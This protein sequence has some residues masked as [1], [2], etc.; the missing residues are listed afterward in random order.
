MPKKIM[1][2]MMRTLGDVIVSTT[3]VK[4]LKK[5]YPD[6]EIYFL[7]NR[8]YGELLRNNPD[9]FQVMESEQ[10][11]DLN[12]IFFEASSGKYDVCF[13]PYQVRGECNIW[14]QR[15]ETR[16]QHLV[17][18]YWQ[19]MGMHRQ[20][21]DRECYLYPSAEDFAKAEEHVS[22]DVPRVALHSTTGVPTKDWPYF[23]ELADLLI[24]AGY[25]P[26]Q[27]G[28]RE[29]KKIERAVDLRG[30]MGFLELAAFLSKCAVFVG[31]DSGPSY[32]ADSMKT[33]CVVIQGSTSPVTSG[34][35]SARVI[36]LFADKTGYPDCENPRCHMNCRHEVNCITK[37][38]PEQ[39]MEK[40]IPILESRSAEC[41]PIP[42][43]I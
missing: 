35:I 6:S 42:A 22:F 23:S 15:E 17:D 14:H 18:F 4:E 40:I 3:I 36:H 13:L 24:K 21:I 34:P 10:G 33:N 26:I 37:I 12:G 29:D 11:W 19:R 25:P 9:V 7:T 16:R 38:K 30:K 20:I 31:L 41:K 27:V 39:V 28:A 32:I 1:F 43:G 8:P 5:E 2:A